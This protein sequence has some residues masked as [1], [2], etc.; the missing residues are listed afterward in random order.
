MPSHNPNRP[1][2]A[3]AFA[4]VAGLGYAPVASGTVG[5]AA[6][7]VLWAI[8]PQSPVVHAAAILALFAGGI[9]AGGVAERYFDTIDPSPVVIDEVMGMLVTLFAVPVGW[10]GALAAFVLFRLM[11]VLKPY[12][13]GHL[14]RLPGGLGVMAD[15]AM[16]AVY[17]N[18]ILHAALA[19]AN[20]VF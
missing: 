1:V 19:L 2:L 16:A 4:T 10:G 11:D 20:S 7:L 13:A 5:S 6:G 3:L 12:P 18:L 9:W 14:E 15:D 8:L 17:A